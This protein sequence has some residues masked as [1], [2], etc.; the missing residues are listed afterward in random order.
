[1]SEA[2]IAQLLQEAEEHL[3]QRNCRQRYERAV[4]RLPDSRRGIWYGDDKRA[5]SLNSIAVLSLTT[6]TQLHSP[7]GP[8]QGLFFCPVLAWH[9]D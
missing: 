9:Q 3:R 5:A 8:L 7:P 4:E 1:M 2:R 6:S